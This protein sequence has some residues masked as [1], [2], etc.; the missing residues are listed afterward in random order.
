MVRIILIVVL[1]TRRV[2]IILL[3]LNGKNN[4]MRAYHSVNKHVFFSRTDTVGLGS[5]G[6]AFL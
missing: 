6:C 3:D 5:L 1:Y 4:D 2:Y